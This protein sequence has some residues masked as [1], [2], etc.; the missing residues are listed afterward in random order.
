MDGRALAERIRGDVAQEVADL[1]ALGLATVLVGDDPASETYIRLKHKAANDVGIDAQD[2]RLPQDI[3]ED[4]LVHRV[5][6]LNR[7]GLVLAANPAFGELVGA[8]PEELVATTAADHTD[9]G[10]DPRVWTAYREGGYPKVRGT[11]RKRPTTI[12]KDV[13]RYGYHLAQQLGP[14][15]IAHIDT[16]RVRRWLDKIAT[17]MQTV[18]EQMVQDH[19][20]T[21]D[22]A[23][24]EID[25]RADR[26]LEKRRWLLARK[27]RP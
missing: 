11:G 26:I 27:E 8:A 15:P 25:R 2:I 23:A 9:L 14:T 1:G 17:E 5:A 18:A 21:I 24:A 13:D 4:D 7:D 22:E 6:V 3:T 16:P 19:R 12:R 20:M 10:A